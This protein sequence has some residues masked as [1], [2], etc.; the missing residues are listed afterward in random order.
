MN[1]P[2]ANPASLCYCPP[3]LHAFFLLHFESHDSTGHRS[4]GCGSTFLEMDLGIAHVLGGG[5][6]TPGV[7]GCQ[8]HA[9]A[10]AKRDTSLA[11]GLDAI[12]L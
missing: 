8:S 6:L 10:A 12:N 5:G 3:A 7:L 4:L 2:R 9:C 1:G 11:Y